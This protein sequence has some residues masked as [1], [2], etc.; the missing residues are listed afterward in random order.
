[1]KQFSEATR[2]QM[3]AMVHLTRIGYTYFGKLSEDKNSTVYDGDT[4]ILLPIFEQQFK[5]LNPEHEGEYLQVLKD[6]RKELNDDDLGRGFYNRLKA[7]SP[8]KLIDFD[9]I[10]NN[11]FHF[12]AEFT[13]K[14]GQDE[15]RPDITLFVNGL[16]LCFVEVKKPNNQGGMLA[17]SAR[18]NKERFPNKKFRRFINIT[19]L[20]IFS[21]NMEYDALGGIVPIQGAFYC[22]GARSYSPFNCFREENLSA[23]KIAPFHRDYPYKDIDKTAEKQIL[24]DYNCQVIHTSPEYQTN[25]DFNTPTNRMLTSMCSPERLL[26][27]IKYGIAYVRMEREVDGKIESTDQKH[28]MRYQQLF[29]SLAI[30]KKLAEGVK[31]GVVW[32]T[33]G[34]GKTA[35]S[36]YLTFILNDFYSKQNKVAKFYFIVDRLD[37]LEQATQEFEARGLVVSTANSR[38]ELMAQFRSNQAQQGVSGQAEITV[39]NIQRFAED[40]EKVRINDYATNLQRIFILDE[41]HRGYKPGGCFLAN[42]FDADTDA[43]KI[44]LT[45][46]PLLKEERASCKVFGNYLHTYYY[47]KS[48]A[49]GYTL[50]IIREDIETSYKERLSDVYDKLETLVQKKDIRK[51]EIIEHPSYVNELARYI[52]TDLKEFRKIQGDDTLG[53]MVICETSEQ[54]RRLYDVFQE[55]WQKYQPKPIKIKLPDGSFIVGEPEVDYKSKYRPLKAGIILHDTD[56]KETRK[57]IVKDFKKNMTV[58]ILIVFNMLLTGFD[59]PRLKRLYF[60]RK[61]KDHN[62]LQAITRVNRPYPG[63]R[64]GFVID[65]ADIKRNFQET[66]EAYLQ[67]LNRFNDVDETGE[68]AVTD[69]FTQ[70]IEDKEEILKQMKQVRQTLFDYSYDNAEEFSSEISTEEDKAVLLDLKQALE[71]AK[72]MANIV[73]TFGDEDMKEQFAKLEITKLPQLLSEV[74][75]RIGIINQK[76]AFSVGEETKTLIN[77]AMMDIEFT[78]SKIGQEELRIVGGKEAIKEKWQRAIASFTQNFDQDDPEFISLRDAFMERFKEHGFVIDSI[79]KFNEETQALDEIIVRLQDLQKRN[80]ALMKKYKGDEK[81]ARVHKRIRE[82]NKQREEKGQKPMFSFLDEEIAAILNIIKE[83]VDAKVY[84]RNDI[85]K[86][87]AYFNRTVMAL[88]NGCLYHFPQIKPEMDDYKFIQTRISQQ[89]INQYSATYGIA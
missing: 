52:M 78:F 77:E 10:G 58:D 37:L 55:E 17:E 49:D 63:M 40:K 86:K 2:V 6:I 59:A 89:Y 53:G 79:A 12:T 26:Y 51:S 18:M 87:D 71:A 30:R 47:D 44:A 46:T 1:M 48:I 88:I 39:V 74:Q 56:D 38:A 61:L 72:N 68:E 13:C 70:V 73:R 22:T 19:Q 27:I 21:N 31:S 69:T 33:Q 62:L 8:V 14:N 85:L 25:L 43:I 75:R 83:D 35:L 41:A 60:G 34:S 67:E 15:F 64:Y 76:E 20:M 11:T 66:N 24:S 81:F 3:P 4:N 45:G 54:A 7:V 65:F 50:K 82:V 32:H 80:N 84:D 29:A 9:N 5:R 42:L 16:P 36:Y 28:V 23:Q 57:Q